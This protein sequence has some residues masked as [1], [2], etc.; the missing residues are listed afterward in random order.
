[1]K[2]KFLLVVTCLTIAFN[3][4]GQNLISVSFADG[5]IGVAA[6]GNKSTSANLLS[7]YGWKNFQFTQNSPSTQFVDQG[8]Q[9]NDIVGTV[10]ITEFNDVQYTI[11]G[12]INWR[13]PNGGTPTTMVFIPTAFT[14][15]LSTN[16]SGTYSIISTTEIGLT[17]DGN[18]VPIISSEVQG[19][20][21]TTGLL[22]SLNTYLSGHPKF[23]QNDVT[24][25]EG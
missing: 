11:P 24:V 25:S 22:T 17:F 13:A 1:M 6:T 4:F 23:Y 8:S 3:S 16:V 18:A 12:Y 10:L 21:A 7:S 19:N 15:I 14:S 20:A 9:G 2:F 5:Y